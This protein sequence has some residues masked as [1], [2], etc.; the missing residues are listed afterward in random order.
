MTVILARIS[1]WN[2]LTMAKPMEGNDSNSLPH[3]SG[4]MPIDS[5]AMDVKNLSKVFSH[6]LESLLP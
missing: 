1:F 6:L 4:N 3:S 2:V 5:I